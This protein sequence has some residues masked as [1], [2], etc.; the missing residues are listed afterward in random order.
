MRT[1]SGGRA[2]VAGILSNQSLT[3]GFYYRELGLFALDPQEGEILYCYGNAGNL[4]EYIPASG[5]PDVV[6]KQIVI[7]TVVGNAAN[8]TAVIDTSLVYATVSDMHLA[9][10]QNLLASK[11]YTDNEINIIDQQIAELENQLGALTNLETEQKANL[12]AAINELKGSIATHLVDKTDPH[13]SKQQAID[14]AKGFGLGS[15]A[16]VISDLNTIN[17]ETGFYLSK[18]NALNTPTG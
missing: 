6:E 18:T 13:N 15:E 14:W 16:K 9:I 10:E 5:G 1:L 8:I 11:N 4:A 17:A 2:E 12:V 3:S 7:Q